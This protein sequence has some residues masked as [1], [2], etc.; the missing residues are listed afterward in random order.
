[1]AKAHAHE[2]RRA[3]SAGVGDFAGE[4]ASEER[5][6][7]GEADDEAGHEGGSAHLLVEVDRQNGND[8][9]KAQHSHECRAHNAPNLRSHLLTL[10]Q[11][12]DQSTGRIDAETQRRGEKPKR[13]SDGLWLRRSDWSALRSQRKTLG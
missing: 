13:R 4:E 7:G 12:E 5:E 9:A 2:E 11:A 10:A 3:A 1:G 6:G 8:R